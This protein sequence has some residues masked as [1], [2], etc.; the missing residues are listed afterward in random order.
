MSSHKLCQGGENEFSLCWI[1][2]WYGIIGEIGFVSPTTSMVGG[3]AGKFC[4]RK[5]WIDNTIINKSDWNLV[6][7]RPKWNSYSMWDDIYVILQWF[8]DDPRINH[9]THARDWYCIGAWWWYCNLWL[10]YSDWLIDSTKF[11]KRTRTGRS[12]QE[13]YYNNN[14]YS[15]L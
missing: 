10:K 15:Y 1:F 5:Q 3:W 6:R 12:D 4:P 2:V 13:W 11:K 14:S 7:C 8:D 9:I